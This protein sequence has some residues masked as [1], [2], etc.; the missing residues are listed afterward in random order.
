MLRVRA[1]I[2][3]ANLTQHLYT[4][5]GC[6]KEGRGR[7]SESDQKWPHEQ[8]D[9]VTARTR[10]DWSNA[11]GKG[12]IQHDE[13]KK[14]AYRAPAAQACS[15]PSAHFLEMLRI[16][17]SLG[18]M[19]AVSFVNVLRLLIIRVPRVPGTNINEVPTSEEFTHSAGGPQLELRWGPGLDR[20]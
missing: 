5:P 7:A 8:S 6:I 10:L 1:P 3:W 20:V 14:V 12:S 19:T 15:H 17:T 4:L 2:I 18:C 11:E 9:P 16:V 13:N